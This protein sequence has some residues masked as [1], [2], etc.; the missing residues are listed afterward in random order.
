MN[1]FKDNRLG[2]V[3]EVGFNIGILS[4]IKEYVREGRAEVKNAFL[5]FLEDKLSKVQYKRE[6]LYKIFTD[7]V[8][9][10][11]VKENLRKNIDYLLFKG[12][13]SGQNF[14]REFIDTKVKLDKKFELIY[15]QADLNNPFNLEFFGDKDEEYYRNVIFKQ[16]GLQVSDDDIKCGLKKG[17]FLKADS[18]FLIKIRNEYH[19][20]VVDNGISLKNVFEL[21]DL[22]TLKKRYKST[23]HKI[24]SKSVFSNLTLDSSNVDFKV[25]KELSNFALAT[26]GKDKSLAKMIQAGSYA[27]SFIRFL[28]SNNSVSEKDIKS[29]NIVGYTDEEIGS[30]N[31][32]NEN[33]NLIGEIRECYKELEQFYNEYRRCDR[34][35]KISKYDEKQKMVFRNIRRNFKKTFNI[36]KEFKMFETLNDGINIKD[37]EEVIE[38]YQNTAADYDYNGEKIGFREAHSREI[39]TCLNEKGLPLMFLTGN[40]GIGKTTSIKKFLEEQESYIFIYVSPRTQVNKD[41]ET[42]LKNDDGIFYSDEV[43]CLTASGIDEKV[44][45]EESVNVVNYSSNS[46]KYDNIKNPILF[47]KSDRAR[48]YENQPSKFKELNNI[49][50]TKKDDKSMGVL[51]RLTTG[52]NYIV[53]NKLSNKIV[54][55]AAVQSLKSI[56][57]D[58]TTAIHFSNI[59]NSIWN[60][61]TSTVDADAC[62]SFAKSYK[63]IIF[64]I[65]EITGD[66]SGV[67]FLEELILK[68]YKKI[69]LQIPEAIRKDMNFKIIVADASITDESVI[70]RHL[71]KSD[72]DTDKIY[73]SSEKRQH[74]PLSNKRFSFK[75]KYESVIINTNSYPAKRLLVKY[76]TCFNITL[77]NEMR[78]NEKDVKDTVN[79]LMVR[80]AVEFITDKKHK[81]LIIYI[82]D[83]RRLDMIK[84]MIKR[85]YVEKTGEAVDEKK[86]ILSINSTMTEYDKNNV[87]LFKGKAKFILMTSSASR[88]I[89]FEK[90]TAILV[91]IPKFDIEKNLMEIIQLIYRGRGEAYIDINCDKFLHFYIAER[92][93]YNAENREKK[94][95]DGLISVLS[96]M[97]ILKSSILTRIQG[98]AE[99]SGKQIALIPIGGKGVSGSEE[100]ILEEMSSLIKNLQ[101]QYLKD[102]SQKVIKDLIE[103][104]KQIFNSIKIETNNFVFNIKVE[105]I[106]S[107]YYE[108]WSIGLH[109]LLDF[110]PFHNAQIVGDIAIFKIDDNFKSYINFIREKI[111]K[112]N[113]MNNTMNIL[114]AKSKNDNKITDSLRNEMGKA[115]SL[116]RKALDNNEDY[117]R[118]MVEK[119]Q[120]QDRYVALPL[121][122]PFLL[123][124]FNEYYKNEEVE[125]N[126]REIL[127]MYIKSFYSIGNVLPLTTNYAE[128]PFITFKSETLK[129]MRMKKFKDSYVFCS[130]EIN[131]INLLLIN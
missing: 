14:F 88:G 47:L 131:L 11:N 55:T 78:H 130:S 90:T 53:E 3:F 93:I 21:T 25:G 9:D 110:K 49:D 116:L 104:L 15:F 71:K 82:Q 80:D 28:T 51:K 43:V 59:F 96:L 42:K 127:E 46:D 35:N 24:R 38:S 20:C 22:E 77:D 31:I 10:V 32:S 63:N 74:V 87:N 60:S 126:F 54:A 19:L 79:E 109:K 5:L 113:E 4:K 91:D 101:K 27:Y 57:N 84:E 73:F 76:R 121:I 61:K 119:I 123:N 23:I 89:S 50:F 94:I 83:I 16:L 58:K 62:K 125:D 124:E 72:V 33:Y 120:E 99:I 92:V 107:N 102:P 115:Y 111:L 105:N 2:F 56:G 13:V 39:M 34:E 41:I 86:D 64:M 12:L 36:D 65:D 114:Y 85:C 75:D 1:D 81:Q 66:E 100:L 129:S 7:E 29:I 18:L 118:R 108:H 128:Y 6:R 103:Q 8:I 40:P 67:Q 106:K 98:Y 17:E 69:F 48:Q 45:N 26:R 95:H 122:T 112:N 70:N 68:V 117:S 44:I 37:I 52:V 97:M 30:I